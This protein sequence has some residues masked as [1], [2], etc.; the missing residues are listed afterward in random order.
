M[1]F[2]N[3]IHQALQLHLRGLWF[4][5]K[6]MICNPLSPPLVLAVALTQQGHLLLQRHALAALLQG[7][8][9]Q[10]ARL[11]GLRRKLCLLM[12]QISKPSATNRACYISRDRFLGRRWPIL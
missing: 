6:N 10:L 11:L 8:R 7:G 9:R 5:L 4:P 3:G 2:I 1:C 12:N